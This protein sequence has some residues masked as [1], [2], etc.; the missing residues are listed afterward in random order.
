MPHM[1]NQTVCLLGAGFSKA[2][3][4]SMP[5]LPELGEGVLRAL[6]LPMTTLQD[7][8]GNVETWLSYLSEEQPWLTPAQNLRNRAVFLEASDAIRSVIVATENAATQEEMP[9]AL[10]RFAYELSATRSDVVTLNYDLLLERA[11]VEVGSSR[12]FSHVYAAP[13]TERRE[14]GT[15]I[16]LS[17]NR[18]DK[19]EM[20][21]RKLHGS[22]NWYYS[23]PDDAGYSGVYLSRIAGGWSMPVSGTEE[24]YNDLAPVVIPPTASKTAF[25][26]NEALRSQWREAGACLRGATRLLIIG[27]S[28]PPSDTQMRTFFATNLNPSAGVVLVDR[29][30]QMKSRILEILGTFRD[31]KTYSGES[32]FDSFVSDNCAH[33]IEWGAVLDSHGMMEAQV[34]EDERWLSSSELPSREELAT[35]R[36]SVAD[37]V[38]RRWP[39]LTSDAMTLPSE[40]GQGRLFAFR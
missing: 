18:S 36:R 2:V 9:I 23:G 3:V 28:F 29:S 1:E 34:R 39:G 8:G 26:K 5:L 24:I 12:R 4:P 10:A 38:D 31:L 16:M 25:Y 6:R 35:G 19:P 13:L 15:G 7:F 14:P 27:Y 22:V 20:R 11:A 30:A 32:A 37:V 17:A 40:S 33:R 21:L